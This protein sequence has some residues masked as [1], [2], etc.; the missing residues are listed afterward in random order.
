MRGLDPRIHV[1]GLLRSRVDGRVKPGHDG[2]RERAMTEKTNKQNDEMG[3]SKAEKPETRKFRPIGL[4]VGKVV[5]L[6]GFFDPL[7]DE[8]CGF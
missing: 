7:P 6:D 8:F 2:V 5:I 1:V 4:D 3:N